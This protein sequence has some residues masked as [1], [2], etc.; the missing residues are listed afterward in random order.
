MGMDSLDADG[1]LV[2][3][4]EDVIDVWLEYDA[5]GDVSVFTEA[6]IFADD[7]VHNSPDNPP[8]HGKAAVLDHFDSFDPTAFEWDASIENIEAGQDLVVLELSY[9]GRPRA[10]ADPD[11]DE[12]DGTSI[13]VFRRHDDG[14]LKQI[15]SSPSPDGYYP[16]E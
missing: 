10:E 15:I 16:L 4:V 7:I 12:V 9:R 3:Q 14:A 8:L 1:N 11:A 5:T 2:T 13:D 6:G